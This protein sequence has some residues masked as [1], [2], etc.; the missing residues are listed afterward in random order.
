MVSLIQSVGY[1]AEGFSSAEDFLRARQLLNTKCLIV[2]VHMPLRGAS[3]YTISWLL[4]ITEFRSFSSLD[5]IMTMFRL[6]PLKPALWDFYAN[7]SAKNRC[8]ELCA[9]AW[10][11]K[12]N[13]KVNKH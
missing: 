1:K 6:E 4:G 7:H 10:P 5:M 8:S 9:L 2:D 12:E 11:V 13:A 3:N